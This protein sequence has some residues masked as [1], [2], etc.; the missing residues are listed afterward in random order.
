M[1]HHGVQNCQQLAHASCQGH[2]GRLGRG[3][4][5]LVECLEYRVVPDRDERTHVSGGPDMGATAPDRPRTPQ[6]RAVPSDGSHS[7]EGREA[8]AAQRAQLRQVEP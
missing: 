3:P 2:F 7:D 8:L 1:F 6:G 5:T 4:Q